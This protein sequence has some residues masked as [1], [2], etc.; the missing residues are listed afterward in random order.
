MMTILKQLPLSRNKLPISYGLALLSRCL[1]FQS[2]YQCLGKYKHYRST[3]VGLKKCKMLPFFYYQLFLEEVLLHRINLTQFTMSMSTNQ[4]FGIFVGSKKK[5]RGKFIRRWPIYFPFI[6]QMRMQKCHV[7]CVN[8]H[9]HVQS[10]RQNNLHNPS[11]HWQSVSKR[12]HAFLVIMQ[13][14]CHRYFLQCKCK[15]RRTDFR[16]HSP[17]CPKIALLADLFL[18]LSFFSYQVFFSRLVFLYFLHRR[19]L[20]WFKSPRMQ[21][22]FYRCKLSTQSGHFH[23]GRDNMEKVGPAMQKPRNLLLEQYK[24]IGSLKQF[25]LSFIE[26]AETIYK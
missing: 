20:T 18:I 3:S 2:S 24:I 9:Q 5:R 14:Q 6:Q 23:C 17:K 19:N 25:K 21:I 15:F 26:R 12:V 22:R 8:T 7:F 1:S 16:N 4:A 11:E 10:G 13:I